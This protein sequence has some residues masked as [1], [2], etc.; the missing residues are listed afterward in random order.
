MTGWLYLATLLAALGCL[1]LLDRR[2]RLVLW[3]DARRGAVV[4]AVGTAL[5]LLWDVAAI[6]AG[7]Y[8]RGGSAGMTGVLLAPELPLEELFFIVFLCY[9]TLVLRGLVD[10]VARARGA[11]SDDGG[12]VAGAGAHDGGGVARAGAH[13]GGRVARAGAHDGAGPAADE[14]AR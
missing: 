3:A 1:A 8:E 12:R 7:F 4:V 2:W 11:R 10:V 13:D 9:L 5:F 6:S 14:E